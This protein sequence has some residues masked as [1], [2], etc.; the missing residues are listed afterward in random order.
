MNSKKIIGYTLATAAALSFAAATTTTFAADPA[1]VQCY[2]VNACKGQAQCKTA[3]NACKG[4]NA[5]KGTGY[6][7]M[8][9]A[10]CLKAGGTTVTPAG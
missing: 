1:E 2:G 6:I 4:Q 7:N 3:K 8:S 9:S 10:D 5:C